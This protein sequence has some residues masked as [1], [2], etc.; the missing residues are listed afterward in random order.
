[1]TGYTGDYPQAH[2]VPSLL[3]EFARPALND[4]ARDLAGVPC[5]DTFAISLDRTDREGH[6]RCAE[7]A[8]VNYYSVAVFNHLGFDRHAEEGAVEALSGALFGGCQQFL[9]SALRTPA[10]P[11]WTR[12]TSAV[13]DTGERL[14]K[15][16]STLDGD[17]DP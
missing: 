4:I 1:M 15:T 14:V 13:P 2:P 16:A 12:V 5:L 6:G 9:A 3:S 11:N 7:D 17:L 10:L 8:V